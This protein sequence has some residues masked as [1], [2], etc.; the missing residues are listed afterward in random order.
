MNV[1]CT[2]DFVDWSL[3]VSYEDAE[4]DE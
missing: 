2:A 4:V 3:W 1:E